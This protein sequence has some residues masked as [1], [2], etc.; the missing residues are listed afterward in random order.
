MTFGDPTQ[1]GNITFADASPATTPGASVAAVQSPTGGGAI[2]LDGFNGTALTV[3]TGNV[4]LSAGTGGIVA[5]GGDSSLATTGQVSL[6]T[7]GGIGTSAGRIVFDA[8]AVPAAVT[9][10]DT[11]RTGRRGLPGRARGLSHWVTY[12]PPTR[13]LTSPQHPT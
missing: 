13:R 9:I 5:T 8:V 11:E 2:I 4:Q 6:D 3:G 7:T 10:G 12:S 1:T